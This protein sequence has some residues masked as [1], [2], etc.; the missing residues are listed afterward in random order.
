MD[1]GY[2]VEN[3]R[4]KESLPVGEH[5]VTA[6]IELFEEKRPAGEMS[7]AITLRIIENQEGETG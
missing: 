1:P 2:Y 7:I 3:I 6:R 4:L 5:P